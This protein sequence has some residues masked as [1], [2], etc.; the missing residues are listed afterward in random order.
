MQYSL[1]AA[2][3]AGALGVTRATLY[4]YTSR[5][6]L[7]SEPM[8]GRTRERR[9]Y[10]EDVERLKERK[11]ARRDP[12]KI[13]ARG[14]EWGG[15]VL[16]SGI[17]LIHNGRL[18]YRGRDAIE[19]A[20]HASVEE[21]AALLWG[22]PENARG[23]LFSEPCILSPAHLRHVRGCSRDVLAQLQIALPVAATLDLAALDLRPSSV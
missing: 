16:E 9:Y 4:A 14:L 23:D 15:P 12:S 5:G 22:A 20:A 7:R 6:L 11:D 10:R 21:A 8:P 18:F 3:A 2:Q 17:T 1:N 13:A 19:L